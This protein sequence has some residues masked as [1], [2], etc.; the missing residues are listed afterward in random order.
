MV[1]RII[2]NKSLL[3]SQQIRRMMT[4]RI[5]HYTRIMEI[6]FKRMLKMH[7]IL[8]VSI[9]M[10]LKLKIAQFLAHNRFP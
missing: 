9:G 4:L 6:L 8:R 5:Q 7:T 3:S 1:I 2:R 10:T